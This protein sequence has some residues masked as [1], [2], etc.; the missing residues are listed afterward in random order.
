MEKK[1]AQIQLPSNL[2]ALTVSMDKSDIGKLKFASQVQMQIA[3]LHGLPAFIELIL[4]TSAEN[5][6]L[7]ELFKACVLCH[8]TFTT[9]RSIRKDGVS[10]DDPQAVAL[11]E[12]I[13]RKFEP[14]IQLVASDMLKQ[15]AGYPK[16]Y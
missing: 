5:R 14:F 6:G 2:I 12:A 15:H 1:E 11:Q 9:L 10:E 16:Q 4:Q 8:K 13:Q 3:G 7:F